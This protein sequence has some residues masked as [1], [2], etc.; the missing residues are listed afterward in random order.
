MAWQV[1]EFSL[2]FDVRHLI[3]SYVELDGPDGESTTFNSRPYKSPVH[4]YNAACVW[5][6]LFDKKLNKVTVYD[7]AVVTDRM[8]VSGIEVEYR[9][10][11]FEQQRKTE[12]AEEGDTGNG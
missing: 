10:E 1:N 4:A 8:A 6:L 5:A 3:F 2:R 12:A 11:E 9:D 7:L